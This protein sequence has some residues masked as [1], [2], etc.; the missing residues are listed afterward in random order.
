MGIF[1]KGYSWLCQ[2]TVPEVKILIIFC[3]LLAVLA[4]LWT[5]LTY[6]ISKI[7]ESSIQIFSYFQCSINGVHD[8]LDCEQ[9][10]KEFEEITVQEL[11][12]LYLV[13][14]S[15]LNLSNLPLIIEYK[16]VKDK[17]TSTINSILSCITVKKNEPPSHI[18][19]EVTCNLE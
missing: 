7:G 10:R 15:F 12:V 1:K 16:S 17:I 19:K 18:G 4:V 9:Y 5:T 14:L 3:Y 2:F 6:T 11:Q 13:L 8:L